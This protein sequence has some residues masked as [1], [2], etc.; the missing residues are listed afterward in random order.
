MTL[1]LIV[2]PF[3]SAPEDVQHAWKLLQI[4]RRGDADEMATAGDLTNLPR[5]WTPGTCPGHVRRS[6]WTWCDDVAAWINST[7]TWRPIQLIPPCWPKH[8]HIASELPAL[9]CLRWL[10]EDSLE[11]GPVEE[12]HRYALP[13]FLE[14]MAARLG[15][16]TCRAGK[17]QGWPAASR[18]VLHDSEEARH[19]R[20]DVIFADSQHVISPH[21]PG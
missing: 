17:H 5:P 10:A 6:I 13:A 16:S 14:R 7:Y 3:P 20:A 15:E 12:W 9:A 2:E 19:E 18:Q 8:P 1:V 21:K 11:P 4:L